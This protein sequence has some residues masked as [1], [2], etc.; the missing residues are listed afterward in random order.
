MVY[1]WLH[2]RGKESWRSLCHAYYQVQGTTWNTQNSNQKLF[3]CMHMHSSDLGEI[4]H[5]AQMGAT[6]GAVRSPRVNR[7]S[8]RNWRNNLNLISQQS[9]NT[10]TQKIT[11]RISNEVGYLCS[12]HLYPWVRTQDQNL[13]PLSLP[14]PCSSAAHPPSPCQWPRLEFGDTW[15]CFH[16]CSIRAFSRND[17]H[18]TKTIKK[19]TSLIKKTAKPA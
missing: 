11:Q 5:H 12:V 8:Q 18:P 16:E 19:C 10:N 9:L 15:S 2:K 1:K 6:G 13:V 3:V 7:S 17:L 4:L 14:F